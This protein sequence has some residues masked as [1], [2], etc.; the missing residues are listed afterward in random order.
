MLRELQELVI[1]YKLPKGAGT[2]FLKILKA[3]VP[4]LPS[5]IRTV[6]KGSPYADLMSDSHTNT[7]ISQSEITNYKPQLPIKTWKEV[8]IFDKQLQQDSFARS[9]LVSVKMV[10]RLSMYIVKTN[11]VQFSILSFCNS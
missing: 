6:M 3:A 11:S 8:L 9:K 2:G 7:S 10:L 1:K 5:D 4:N